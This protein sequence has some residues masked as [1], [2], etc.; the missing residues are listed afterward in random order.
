MELETGIGADEVK[1]DSR[2]EDEEVA[3]LSTVNG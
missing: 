2:D 1:S 3:A